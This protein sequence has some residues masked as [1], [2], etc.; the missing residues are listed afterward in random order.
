MMMRMYLFLYSV[1]S[2]M[3]VWKSTGSEQ[4]ICGLFW[5]LILPTGL[6]GV[7]FTV[8]PKWQTREVLKI[9]LCILPSSYRLPFPIAKFV[10]NDGILLEYIFQL[11]IV[12]CVYDVEFFFF[13]FLLYCD[14]DIHTW[15]FKK[16]FV[17]CNFL[18][19]TCS[20][21]FLPRVSF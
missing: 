15:Y 13:F 4:K 11:I 8:W 1:H 16:V 21:S 6:Q 17:F 10:G 3:R 9:S 20:A 5:R 18:G 7:L 2:C 12:A 14:W 19:K